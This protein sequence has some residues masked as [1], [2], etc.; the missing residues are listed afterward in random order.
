MS[1]SDLDRYLVE[2]GSTFRTTKKIKIGK[3]KKRSTGILASVADPYLSFYTDPDPGSKKKKN[4]LIRIQ[5]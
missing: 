5:K 3:I 2:S 1:R 4:L